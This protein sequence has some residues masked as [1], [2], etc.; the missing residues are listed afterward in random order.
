MM[1]AEHTLFLVTDVKVIQELV[2]LGRP[3]H[4]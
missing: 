2:Y 3:G 4:R 1:A